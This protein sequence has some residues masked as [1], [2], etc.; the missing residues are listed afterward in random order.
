[1]DLTN[2]TVL[3]TGAS[4][5]IGASTAARMSSRGATVVLVARREA[6]L[7]EVAAGLPGRAEVVVC[8]VADPDAVAAMAEHVTDTVGTPDVIVNN[9]GAGQWRWIEETSPAE[10]VSQVAV[11]F[12]AAFF[13]T[14]AFIEPMLARGSGWVVTVNSP[15]AYWAWPGAIGYGSARWGLRGFEEC[16]A[17]D[18]RGTGIG[19]TAVVAGH[20]DSD[21]FAANPGSLERIP[22]LDRYFRRL[23]PDDVAD[24]VCRGVEQ[25]RRRVVE[26]LEIRL[27]NLSARL[28]PGLV[29]WLTGA[30]G[31]RRSR[32]PGSAQR[33]R[34]STKPSTANPAT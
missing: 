20:T 9:A 34:T 23:T 12:H 18:L 31:A 7:R 11:P 14:R 10:F 21:Y 24:M 16:L 26:P 3:V 13:V 33:T 4:A 29:T 17:A 30:T 15:I 32:T 27:T 8:D 1:M 19:V 22:W 25:E 6:A 2:R 5:G 28:A